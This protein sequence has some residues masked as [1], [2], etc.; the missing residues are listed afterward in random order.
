L[1]LF[2]NVRQN[3]IAFS[4]LPSSN[5]F[6]APPPE[7]SNRP[8]IEFLALPPPTESSSRFFYPP[9]PPTYSFT[10]QAFPVPPP[11]A[12][13]SFFYQ[14]PPP[15]LSVPPP[16]ASWRSNFPRVSSGPPISRPQ[17]TRG[18]LRGPIPPIQGRLQGAGP[19]PRIVWTEE[20]ISRSMTQC[21]HSEDYLGGVI[22]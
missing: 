20:R 8:P 15:E 10:P 19:R 16:T 12:P 6:L 4:S 7:S 9:P 18:P 3:L 1:T 17:P 5:Q 21:N 2:R 22:Q 14:P 13:W 11:T